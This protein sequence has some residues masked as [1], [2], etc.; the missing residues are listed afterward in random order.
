VGVLGGAG[1]GADG[2][3]DPAQLTDITGISGVIWWGDADQAR[4]CVRALAA[5]QGPILPLI[6]SMPDAGHV[7]HERHLCVDTT[8]AGGNAALLAGEVE[9]A[10]PIDQ[11]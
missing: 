2:A 6:T 5:R 8:A 4:A 9:P 3:I 11:A 7:L 10:T 1:G